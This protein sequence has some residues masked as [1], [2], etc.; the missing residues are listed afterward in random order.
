M[1]LPVPEMAAVSVS[2][3]VN[4][5]ALSPW[6]PSTAA[7][8][9]GRRRSFSIR[10]DRLTAI[11]KS[12]ALADQLRGRAD[13]LVEHE[14][15]QLADPVALLGG[16]DEFGRADRALFGMGPARQRLGAD[17][18]AG[19]EVELG[20]IG[21]PHLAIVDRV[22]EL[23][24]QRQAPRHFLQPRRIVEFP[25]QRFAVGFVGGD[26]RAAQPARHRAAAAD[27]DPEAQRHVDN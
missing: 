10:A 2:S 19:L 26:Q 7:T 22:V 27:F 17:R 4:L 15:G 9:S 16:G 21:E 3:S 23:R 13:R 8:R 24:Q 18:P 6:R 11:P 14:V 20:L 1:P 5:S 12:I 25:F